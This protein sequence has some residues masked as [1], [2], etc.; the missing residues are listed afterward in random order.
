[1][2][3]YTL[4]ALLFFKNFYAN[5][6]EEP[7]FKVT[8]TPIHKKTS[9]LPSRSKVSTKELLVPEEE[10]F[11]K[12]AGLMLTI[13][14][15]YERGRDVSTLFEKL[16]EY[17]FAVEAHGVV[18]IHAHPKIAE[19]LKTTHFKAYWNRH[20]SY[21]PTL[22]REIKRLG[23]TELA[24]SIG[25]S[26]VSLLINKGIERQIIQTTQQT[27][28]I[29]GQ[30]HEVVQRQIAERADPDQ[31][32][33]GFRLSQLIAI[34]FAIQ[35]YLKSGAPCPFVDLSENEKE[36]LIINLKRLVY[37]EVAFLASM[38][39]ILKPDVIFNFLYSLVTQ[40][41]NTPRENPSNQGFRLQD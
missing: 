7:R 39:I 23:L 5:K 4:I 16:E 14:A 21:L 22:E 8:V 34:A 24:L 25:P 35:T 29:H 17:I 41:G 27:T 12:I 40:R 15:A 1:M 19:V 9:T 28:I 6:Q 38:G 36:K 20:Y 3:K 37:N 10:I 26:V 13:C 11:D 33:I 2:K 30:A 18:N 32:K 31:L